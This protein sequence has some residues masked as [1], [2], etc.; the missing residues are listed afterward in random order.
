ML[1]NLGSMELDAIYKMLNVLA[2]GLLSSPFTT[3][4]LQDYLQAHLSDKI[5]F[6]QGKYT[7][8]SL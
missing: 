6:E 7:L 1:T 8:R 2:S 4:D 3:H 5:E